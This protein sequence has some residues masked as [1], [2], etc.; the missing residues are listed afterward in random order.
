MTKTIFGIFD[1]RGNAEGA[2][3]ELEDA[4]FRVKDISIIMKDSSEAQKIREVTPGT[5]LGE[6]AA[7]GAT[8]GAVLGGLAGLLIG[9]GAIAIPGIGGLL[10]AG[11]LAATLGLT[12][13]A[14]TTVSGAVTGALAGGILGALVRLGIPEN[15]A[16]EYETS[17]KAGGILLAVPAEEREES[18][19]REILEDHHAANV[20][21]V[22]VGVSAREDSEE[23]YPSHRFHGG[24]TSRH[25]GAHSHA[26]SVEVQKYL[27]HVDYPATKEELIHTAED[28]GADERVLHT[29]E[30]LPDEEFESPKTVAQ[31]ISHH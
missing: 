7:E 30:D 24:D 8:T 31:A 4:G 12:G 29:L 16:R 9:I 22:R 1:N 27:K 17:I 18:E 10:I 6:G 2:L 5:T 11:P 20:D 19:V 14:A 15:R 3:S 25:A 21:A 28:E 23:K 26:N 13:A